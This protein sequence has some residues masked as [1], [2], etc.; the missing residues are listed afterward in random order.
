MPT[1]G[2]V[3]GILLSVA[4]VLTLCRSA[5]AVVPEGA[6]VVRLPVI[7]RQDVRFVPFSAG[8]KSFQGRILSIA[9]DNRGFL[10][11]GAA[12]G[13][14]R[15]DGYGLKPYLH[16][17]G[18]P[19]TAID[20]TIWIVY[21]DRSGILWVGTSGG[22]DRVDPT[23]DTFRHYRHVPGDALSLSDNAVNSVYQ[24]RSGALWV[25]TAAGLDRLDPA[26]GTFAHYR[27]DPNDAGTLSS[28]GIT[29]ITEDRLGNLWVG[30]L[31]GLNKLDRAT[32]RIS[33][34]LQEPANP[35]GFGQDY[36][37]FIVEDHSG[38]LWLASP[39]GNGL[40]AL[41]VK[42]G[43]FTRYS[44]RSEDPGGQS[45]VGVSS[46]HEDRDGVL[47]LG[48]VD[49]GLLKLDRERREFVRYSKDAANP[50]SLP[51]DTVQCMFEDAEGVMWLGTSVGP[52]SFLKRPQPFVTYAHEAR[53]PNSL[54]DNMIWSTHSDGQGFYWIGTE[55]GLDRLDPKTGDFA[56]YQHNPKDRYSLSYDKVSTIREDRSGTLWFGTYGGGL[57]RF[58]RATGRFFAYRHDKKKPDSL[59]SDSILCSFIDRQGVLW[60]GTQAGGLDRFD[61]ATGHFKSYRNDPEDPHSLSKDDVL[62]IYEDKAG[63]MWIGTAEGLNRFDPNT[64]HF[65]AYRADS[66]SLSSLSHKKVN[67][68]VEDRHG[69]LWVGTQSGLDQMD[70]SRGTFAVYT[71]KDGL[72]DNAIKSIVEDRQ[73]YL[74]L[75]T[76]DGLSRFDPVEK[77]FRNYSESDGLPGSLLSPYGAEGSF[78][79]ESG[80][81]VIGSSNGLTVVH[82][83][84]LSNNPS[85]PPVVLTALLLFNVPVRQGGKSPIHKPIWATDS[86]TLTHNQ[87]IFTLEF[88][89]LSYT[90]PENNRYRYRLEGLEKEWNE[91]DSRQR[92]ATYTNLPAAKYIFRVQGSNNDGLWNRNGATLAITVLPPWWATWWFRSLAGLSMAALIVAAYRTRIRNLQLAGMRLEAQVAERT[93]ELESAKDAAERANRAKS[94]FLA[95][96]SHELRTPLNAILGFS[97]LV[98]DDPGLS[99]KHRQ[100][101]DIVSRG[102]EHLLGLIDDVLDMAKIEAGRIGL[103][104]APFDLTD[105][106]RDAVVVMQARARDKGLE[107]SLS[108]SSTVPRFVWSDAG[109]L[110]QLLVNLIGNAVKYT[111]RGSVTVHLDASRLDDGNRILLILEV[112][113]TGIGIGPEDQ[114]RIFDVFFQ[115]GTAST[116]KGTGLGLSIC[117]QFAQLMG[118]TISA[119][120]ALGA[121]SVFRVELPV[122]QAEESEVPAANDDR[123]KVVGLVPGQPEQ[124]ILIVE[125]K[126]E[127]WLLL[128]RL[129]LDAGFQVRVAEDGAQ[130][131]E[132]F[133]IWQP[134]LIWMDLRLPVMGGL[135]ATREIR[136]L[137]GGREVRIV[138]LTASAFTQQREEVMAAGLDDFL[139][140]PYRREEIFDCMARHLGVRYLYKQAS[141]TAPAEPVGAVTPEALAPLSE[142]LREE[143][144]NAVVRLDAGPIRE[145]I[146]RIS[147]QD[148]QLGAALA[149]CAD[150]LAY[151]E[152][153]DALEHCNDRSRE[154]VLDR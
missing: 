52:T 109:K 45:V 111:E 13:L 25:G 81:I 4:G 140:K 38:V 114:G 49:S 112:E 65:S 72:A 137:D 122:E 71:T 64:E 108:I 54:R 9:Q 121:G 82:P 145:V 79:D 46:L 37:D 19:N 105:I 94:A 99:E 48:T 70:R 62:V 63:I 116:Q 131:V 76:E 125:D 88:A 44:F 1:Y 73:G 87:S 132:M 133:R 118:G 58:D 14:Y 27:N 30:T 139:R 69:T 35:H 47:W 97:A 127:N 106:V 110:R 149:N 117:R 141:R 96:M 60:L 93:R 124:R 66:G 28:N 91:V 120:S 41:N 20:D 103:E 22:L 123:G 2:R 147:E 113:D 3:R 101:L 17:P 43:V 84:R 10:W 53:S 75:A 138:A 89:A 142:Q 129:L 115:A 134:H 26:K 78:R 56:L 61:P 148:A 51:H 154:E 12:D 128:Q 8:G 119:R 90:A 40:S 85:A 15:Y 55:N 57:D 150:R 136:A 11:F 102:G 21:K 39:I 50:N 36:L 29:C 100:N 6:G 83:D 151:T 31:D 33:R 146:G 153:L 95:N 86:L 104:R 67:A 126:R 24:D 42:T 5:Y 144:A 68:I 92:L 74:W 98:R 130:G 152:I 23:Q 32:G 18:D 59:S 34:F 7:D 16:D 77:T 80:E 135:E 107:L 143:L